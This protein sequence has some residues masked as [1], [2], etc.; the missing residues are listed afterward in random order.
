MK[1]HHARE[2]ALDG[3]LT[4]ALGELGSAAARCNVHYTLSV[5]T[6]EGMLQTYCSRGVTI[7]APTVRAMVG[8]LSTDSQWL[9]QVQTIEYGPP[10]V[11][12]HDSQS[13]G[14]HELKP[15][16]RG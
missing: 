2:A 15:V 4:A 12:T 1:D 10:F 13:E 11:G 5:V 14:A 3:H 16:T 6:H 8:C 9:L 7:A